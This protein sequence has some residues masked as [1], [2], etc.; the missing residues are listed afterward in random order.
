MRIVALLVLLALVLVVG[1]ALVRLAYV[2]GGRRPRAARALGMRRDE[3]R[4][5][6]GRARRGDRRGRRAPRSRRRDPH[7]PAHAGRPRTRRRARSRLR[8]RPAP[9]R[10]SARWR[11]SSRSWGSASSRRGGC[12]APRRAP[13][14]AT[15]VRRRPRLLV[16][17]AAFAERR[18]GR[19]VRARSRP[20]RVGRPA[21][22]T[23]VLG[24]TLTIALLAG[25]WSFQVSLQHMLDTPR[26]YGWNWSVK[27]GAPALPDARRRAG[28]GVRR[29]TRWSGASRRARSRRPSSGSSGST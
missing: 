18:H 4:A 1:Q 6:R 8:R 23:T 21:V 5:A 10:R 16:G 15:P 2:R 20:G 12:A 24:A 26:L 17:G 3:L 14:S 13:V 28:A 7:V 29:T 11:S 27:S 9:A 19:A 25:L 22:W